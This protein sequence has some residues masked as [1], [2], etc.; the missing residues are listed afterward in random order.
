MKIDIFIGS[1]KEGMGTAKKVK[2]YLG[3]SSECTIWTEDFFKLNVSYFDN[4]CKKTIGFDFAILIGTKDDV[5]QIRKSR[6]D[7]IRD[8]VMFEYGLFTG[9][10]GRQRTFILIQ[11]GAKLPSDLNGISLPVFKND[12]ELKQRCK[13]ILQY[14]ES[15][16][17]LSR[18]SML[19]STSNA[20]TYYE[21]FLKPVCNSI[22]NGKNELR[23]SN[24]TL[25][26][27]L[28]VHSD[29]LN[30][31]LP[32]KLQA[33]MK[34]LV[35]TFVQAHNFLQVSIEGLHRNHSLFFK[36]I[37]D[38]NF[39]M[40]IPTNLNS[41]FIAIELFIGK[42]YLGNENENRKYAEKEIKNFKDTLQFLISENGHTNHLAKILTVEEFEKI[43]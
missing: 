19:P 17:K 30:V 10:I 37:G 11:N 13:E 22:F 26:G 14:I 40:D 33:D 36:K 38:R 5:S 8:N 16:I 41:S 21:N 27:S 29:K 39:L 7:T 12:E 24:N 6:Y 20:I 18:I 15:E 4:L 28:S 31:I 35:D 2:E 9:A 1:S 32:D 23:L 42:D 43:E 34:P 25:A 3:E